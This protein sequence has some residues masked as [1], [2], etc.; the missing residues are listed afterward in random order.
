VYERYAH[1]Y[2]WFRY[3]IRG[4]IGLNVDFGLYTLAGNSLIIDGKVNCEIGLNYTYN[5]LPT[6]FLVP[7]GS[8]ESGLQTIIGIRIQNLKIPITFHIFYEI[9]YGN[10]EYLTGCGV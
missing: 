7:G 1:L 9:P 3:A 10:A 8:L 4:G 5:Y 2:K 6:G